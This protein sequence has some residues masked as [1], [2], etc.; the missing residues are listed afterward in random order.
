M[1]KHAA[2]RLS[3]WHGVIVVVIVMTS[4]VSPAFGQA[5]GVTEDELR[6]GKNFIPT[7][8]YSPEE[9]ERILKLYEGLRVADVCDGMDKAGLQNIGLVSPEIQ[10]LWRDTENFTHRIVGIAVTVRYVPTNRPPI[11][12]KETAEFNEAV[13]Q[14]YRELSPEPFIPLLR[15]GTVLVI[16]DAEGADVGTIGSNNIL[17]W[18]LRGCV[19]VVTNASARD[20]DEI[21]AQRVPLYFKQPGRGIRPGRN[22]IESVNRPV[23]I[24]GVLVVP[25]DVI[26]ADGDGVIVVPR[27]YAEEVALYA[28][29][30]LESDKAARRRLYEKLGMPLDP[31]V[32]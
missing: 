31:S 32:K 26:V 11:G 18:K 9:D 25:G 12:R 3:T 20:T 7:P 23:V 2:G 19:G 15:K 17:A 1:A 16:E 30:I 8:V 4:G 13:S 24:G 14:W 27:Q 10:P 22:Q 6:A 21:I 5:E 29:G 28:R